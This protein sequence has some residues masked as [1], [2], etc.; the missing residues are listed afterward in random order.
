MEVFELVAVKG[1][2]GLAH[3]GGDIFSINNED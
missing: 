2:S 3:E 1:G